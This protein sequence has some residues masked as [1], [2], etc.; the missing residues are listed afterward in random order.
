MTIV[1]SGVNK[2]QRVEVNDDGTFTVTARGAGGFKV[3]G[4]NQT[5]RDPGMILV[6]FVVD[7]MGTPQDP[8]DDEIIEELGPIGESTGLNELGEDFCSDYL[9]LTGRA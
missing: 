2:D 6:Q 8:E 9:L 5:L 3:I 4:P 1:S 7:T